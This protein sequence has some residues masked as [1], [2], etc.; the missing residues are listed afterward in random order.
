MCFST[1]AAQQSLVFTSAEWDFGTIRETDGPVSHTFTGENRGDK[2]LV[3]LD[4]VTTCGCT[5]PDFSRQPVTPKGKTQI[6]VT[7]DPANRPGAFTK[8]LGVYSTDRRKIATLTV[9][10]SVTPRTKSIEERYPIDAGGGLRLTSTLCT[11]SYIYP[12]QRMQS[13]VGFA[14]AS[15]RPIRLS[16]LPQTASGLLDIE[17]PQ[18]IAAGEQGEINFSYLVPA[19][20]PRYG[21]V[22]DALEVRTDD[23]T[24]GTLLVTHAIGADNPSEVPNGKTPKAGIDEI[25]LKFGPVKHNAPV[26]TLPF[27]LSNTGKGE[28]IVRA[29]ESEGR[30]TASLAPG[31]R[32]AA[33]GKR[34]FEVALDPA[35]QEYGILTD[36]LILITNDP[37]RPM[38]RLR[39]TAVIEQ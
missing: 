21:T 29:V 16:L 31:Q 9:R 24:N 27:T 36:H 4:V 10:G 12:G 11:F 38:R 33:G 20:N 1:A 2:P 39:V 25:I 18:L 3:I 22:R 7:Y 19:D 32:I 26:Q 8:T 37:A 30:I 5:V 23:R 15:P 13:S 35:V 17:Y 28:L 14:N 6:T 34:T